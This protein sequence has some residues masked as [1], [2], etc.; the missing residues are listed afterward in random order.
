ME[1]VSIST[2]TTYGRIYS[3]RELEFTRAGGGSHFDAIKSDLAFGI[4][5]GGVD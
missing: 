3:T 4:Y 5:R 2:R 1:V